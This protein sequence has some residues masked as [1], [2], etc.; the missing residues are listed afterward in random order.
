MVA[1]LNS[2]FTIFRM[3]QQA[4]DAIGGAVISGT[5]IYWGIQGRLQAEPATQV[6]AEQG[7]ET[8]RQF[9]IVLVPGTLNVRERDE[10]ELRAPRDHNYYGKRFRIIGMEH[11]SHTPRDPRNYLVLHVTRS[12]RAHTSQ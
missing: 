12:V 8:E 1:G 7:L 6:F 9:T 2:S 3:E 10:I 5:A 4:D 11:S